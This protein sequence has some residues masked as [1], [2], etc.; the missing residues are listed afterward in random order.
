MKINNFEVEF[1]QSQELS[2]NKQMQVSNIP[3]GVAVPYSLGQDNPQL[4]ISGLLYA[5]DQQTSDDIARQFSHLCSNHKLL[6]YISTNRNEGLYNG[7]YYITSG[8]VTQLPAR[9]DRPFS[10]NII[11]V[12]GQNLITFIQGNPI[13]LHAN[14]DIDPVY[15]LPLPSGVAYSGLPVLDGGAIYADFLLDTDL[16]NNLNANIILQQPDPV[17]D[18]IWEGECLAGDDMGIIRNVVVNFIGDITISNDI[19][20]LKWLESSNQNQIEIWNGSTWVTLGQIEITAN[21]E[22][23]TALK[24]TLKTIEMNR[25]TASFYYAV[26]SGHLLEVIFTLRKAHE[27]FSVEVVAGVGVAVD[28]IRIINTSDI[29]R[30]FNGIF[31]SGDP[32]TGVQFSSLTNIGAAQLDNG[33]Y[34][35]FI[36]S[37]LGTGNAY[38]PGDTANSTKWGRTVASETTAQFGILAVGTNSNTHITNGGSPPDLGAMFHGNASSEV[39]LV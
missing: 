20:R 29:S 31:Q 30:L 38:P 7:W 15:L 12:P 2:T 17:M 19:I 13:T 22:I 27:F 32:L 1:P 18:N 33:E 37:G 8:G 24:P 9:Y 36:Y 3:D 6:A 11:R 25:I 10:A 5:L 23:A 21:A 34:V 14:F 16:D 39:G 26:S 28:D 4:A 35:G